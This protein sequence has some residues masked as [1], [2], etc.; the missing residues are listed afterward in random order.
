MNRE[1]QRVVLIG[2]VYP[3]KGG[4]AHYDA[5]LC[6]E[7]RKKYEVLMISYK[8][9]YPKLLF[10]KPQ[11]DYSDDH[12]KVADTHFILNSANPFN[13]AAVAQKIREWKPDMIILPWWHPYFAPCYL[14]LNMFLPKIKK[15][16]ICHNV[17]PHER[18]VFDR[19]LTR[20]TLAN[21]D[22]FIVH[23][24][25]DQADLYSIKKDANS[26]FNPIP[27]FSSF[28]T[29]KLTKEQARKLLGYA[30]QEKILL[31]FGFVR[32]YKGLI[33]LLHALPEIVRCNENAKLLI[34]GDF[35]S[36]RDEYIEYIQ[37]HQLEKYIQVVEGYVP[38]SE[39]EKYFEACDLVILPYESA[40]QSGIVQIAFG[41]EKPVIVTDVGGLPDVVTKGRTGYIVQAKNDAAIAQAVTDFFVHNRGTMMHRNIMAEAERF[42]W[43]SLVD[44][45]EQLW[46]DF[47]E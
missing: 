15:C 8:M 17:F 21:G 10:K 38:D 11:K 34:V 33:H 9:M 20:H 42:S 23:S 29:G 18:F 46:L 6:E 41:F 39:V 16:Y 36:D 5:M 27:S 47:R 7:L 44:C 1:L 40:T 30:E 22:G 2:P 28:R 25:Q 14:L 19:F 32:K 37:R 31:F 24:K 3:Y 45:I 35:D 4:I 43:T 26:R 12:F 13:I